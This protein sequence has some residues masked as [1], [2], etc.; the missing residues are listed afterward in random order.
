MMKDAIADNNVLP[1]Q[2][3]YIR[4]VFGNVAGLDSAMLDDPDYCYANGV[5]INQ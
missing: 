4:T 2:V 5:N 1:F 3:E